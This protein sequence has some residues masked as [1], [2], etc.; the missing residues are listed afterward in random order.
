MKNIY[1][2]GKGAI[3]LLLAYHLK[4]NKQSVCLCLREKTQTATFFYQHENITAPFDLNQEDITS[5][6]PINYLIIPTKSYSVLTAFNT[7][8]PRL[9]NNATIVL[10]HN[11]M[12]T[13]EQILPLIKP[14]QSLFFLTTS[15]GAY[16][17][18][19]YKVIHTGKGFSY[20][21]AVNHTAEKN[22]KVTY[23]KL[24]LSIPQLIFESD[25][26]YLLWKKLLINIAINPL[27]AL[28]R[29]KNGELLN[30]KYAL[31]IFNLV[32]EAIR[33]A[34]CH[35]L[36][37]KL[38]EVLTSAYQVM[39]ATAKNYSSMNRDITLNKPTEIDAI[40]GYIVKLGKVYGVKTPYNQAVIRK[41]SHSDHVTQDDKL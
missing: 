21:G 20:L 27:S 34:H 18:D 11:G 25:I 9:T 7:I 6:L 38:S 36:K 16:K 31:E 30:P 15:M 12:G 37:F 8:K 40:C 39:S 2:I 23:Q 33:I 32:D 5:T 17:S 41:I 19:A 26:N 24:A 14:T 35:G 3:G 4:L 29:V 28:Y 13:V 1:I 10:C 22:Q